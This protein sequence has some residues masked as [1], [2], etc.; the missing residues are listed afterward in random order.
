M[1]SAIMPAMEPEVEDS[2]TASMSLAHATS[3]DG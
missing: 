2:M 3:Q 1:G